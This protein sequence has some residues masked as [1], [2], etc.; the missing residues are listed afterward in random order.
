MVTSAGT[1][2]SRG[3]CPALGGIPS[4][5]RANGLGQG[6]DL[7]QGLVQGRVWS[8]AGFELGQGFS[9]SA[10]LPQ[11]VSCLYKLKPCCYRPL[12][13]VLEKSSKPWFVQQQTQPG[14]GWWLFWGAVP[15]LLPAVPRVAPWHL[16][17]SSK[18][19]CSALL[20]SSLETTATALDCFHESSQQEESQHQRAGRCFCE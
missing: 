20:L 1:P 16:G 5:S 2:F 17:S 9:T 14:R 7:G 11:E 15:S 13:K 18:P 3:Q 6:F 4:F 8:R 10:E 19:L 12:R